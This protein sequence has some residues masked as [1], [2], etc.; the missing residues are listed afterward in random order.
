MQVPSPN[1]QSPPPAFR[2]GPFEVDFS[3]GELRKSGLLVHVQHQPLRVLEILLE[4]PGTIVTREQLRERLWSADTF[5]DFD[6]SLNSAVKKLRQAIGD[7]PDAPRYLETLPGRGY[8][9]R[10]E[11]SPIVGRQAPPARSRR[12]LAFAGLGLIAAIAIPFVFNVTQVRDRAWRAIRGS[13]SPIPVPLQSIAV[14]PLENLSGDPEQEYFAEG[15]TDTLITNL[16]QI[17]T[18]HVISRASVMRYK[19]GKT[20]LPQIVRELDV[21]AVVEGTVQRADGKILISVQLLDARRDRHLW[22]NT[23]EH[24]AEDVLGLERKVALAIAHEISGRVTP[25]EETRLNSKRVVNREA[26]DDYLRGRYLLGQRTPEAE[27]GARTYFDEARRLD[28]GF[29]LAYSGL[30]DTYSV[31]WDISLDLTLAEQYGREAV[32]LD[33]DLAEG[34]ASVGIAEVYEHKFVDAEKELQRAIELNPN[35]AMAHHWY[36]LYLIFLDRPTEAL[37]ANAR[38][39]R[40]DPFSFP[41][42][43]LRGV[44][45]AAL[46]ED[47][48]AVEQLRFA[49][50]I[51][52]DST[53]PHVELQLVY[54]MEGRV[55]EALS[56][57][58]IIATLL[59]QSE[60]PRN[61]EE[62][63]AANRKAGLRAARL[64]DVEIKERLYAREQRSDALPSSGLYSAEEIAVCYALLHEKRKTLFWLNR[65]LHDDQAYF[66]L[67]LTAPAFDWLRSDGQLHALIRRAGLPL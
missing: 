53:S 33:P 7:E 40:L 52:P 19:G 46:Q 37:A 44:M 20:P 59:H 10:G 66:S 17:A 13:D 31:S 34:H 64:K 48:R 11:V 58:E 5:V 65:A 43:Y 24:S 6:H 30:A 54:W 36:S 25:A 18:M 3:L 27:S 32:A 47:A 28:P 1:S 23:Y 63:A 67:I 2:F 62:I 51:N 38:A 9:F 56:E 49:A 61:A 29:A 21:D 45:L 22:A 8:R 41:I 14:L 35:Y 4:H 15:L 60:G 42:N 16:G 39:R 57:E 26:Y 50:S 55:G 12:W